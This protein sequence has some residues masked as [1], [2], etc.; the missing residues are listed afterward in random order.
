[1]NKK[2][3]SFTRSFVQ[4]DLEVTKLGS[5]KGLRAKKK[6]KKKKEERAESFYV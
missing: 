2:L 5:Q 4:Y 1:M 3:S 6:T